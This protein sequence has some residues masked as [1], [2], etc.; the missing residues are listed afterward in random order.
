MKS[1]KANLG[2]LIF[3][4]F[5]WFVTGMGA[6]IVFA[7]ALNLYGNAGNETTPLMTVSLA[8][9][10]AFPMVCVQTLVL[11][12]RRFISGHYPQIIKIVL[13]PFPVLILVAYLF[14]HAWA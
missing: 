9:L 6:A 5:L 2:I 11:G 4:S 12:W 8:S 7:F 10:I 13:L 1:R 3:L 14:E